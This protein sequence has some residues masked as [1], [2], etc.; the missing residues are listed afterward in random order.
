MKKNNWDHKVL[1]TDNRL[2]NPGLELA[3]QWRF[4][5]VLGFLFVS[6]RLRREADRKLPISFDSMLKIWKFRNQPFTLFRDCEPVA[7]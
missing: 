1:L 3:S 2:L 5:P 4:F 7:S 6:D